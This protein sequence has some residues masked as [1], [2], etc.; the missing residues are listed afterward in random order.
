M[1]TVMVPAFNEEAYLRST[2]ESLIRSATNNDVELDVIIINDG[3]TDRTQNIIRELESEFSFIRSI[4]NRKNLGLG[5]SLKSAVKKGIG[6]KF[7]I[8]GGDGDLSEEGIS[9][10]FKH[11]HKAEITS[12]YYLNKEK[13]GRFRNILST[14]YDTM[15][16]L[17][18][19]IYIQY[20][21][22]A[23]V[24]PM[25]KLKQLELNSTRF[26]IVAEVTV[27]LL[28]TG[29]TYQE[30]PSFMERGADGSSAIT[31]KNLFEVCLSFV[32]LI[33][34]VLIINR[35]KYDHRPVRIF[36]K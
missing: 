6:D 23:C 5:V 18:F 17:F 32:R 29:C 24:Y 15:Y 33:A 20:I 4:D 35:Q 2:V 14:V 3:S 31:L 13:R 9:T 1:V 8:V 34:D 25:D 30:Y 10:L 19:N 36:S 21:N 27:K 16:V 26:A 12:L 22:A 28:R 7:L 11:M